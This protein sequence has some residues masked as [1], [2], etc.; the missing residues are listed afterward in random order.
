MHV[1]VR[2]GNP[3]KTGAEIIA[4]RGA[5]R[6]APENTIPAFERALDIG[7]HGI[8]LDVHVTRD[9]VPVVHHDAVLPD[10]GRI[11]RMDSADLERRTDAPRLSEV[12][13]LVNGRCRLYVEIK[14]PTAA[15]PCVELLKDLTGWCSIH[16]FDHRIALVSR[17]LL[18]DINTGILLVSRLIDVVH[19]F[20]SAKAKDV[21]QNA[22]YVDS[23]LID[24]AHAKGARVMWTVNDVSRAKELKAIGV[25]GICTDTPGELL[26]G[27]SDSAP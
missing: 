9:N 4:H 16:S 1:T 14:T 17:S 27:L 23:D 13:D 6:E 18:P 25:D 15:V 11:D 22:D 3:W 26:E 8:E 10:G 2:Q 20:H 24:E 5:N 19:A 7:V 21:W 12:L